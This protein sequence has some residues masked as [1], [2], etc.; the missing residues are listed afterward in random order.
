MA[1]PEA[2][3]DDEFDTRLAALGPFETRPHLAVA[4]SGGP[5]SMALALLANS[6]VEKRGG[7]LTALT[8]DHRLRSESVDEA[9]Q[10]HRWMDALGVEH[11]VLVWTGGK[12]AT[13]IQ[14]AA[15]EARYALLGDWCRT[16]G[17]L[18]LL[19]GHHLQ[20]QAET[21]LLRLAHGSGVDGLA[22]MAS[23]VETPA[24]RLLRPLLGVTPAALREY[25]GRRKQPWIDD[26]SNDDPRFARTW[27][28]RALPAL[29]GAGVGVAGL[30]AAADRVGQARAA[31]EAATGALLA[32]CCRLHPAGFARVRLP[33]LT[34]AP[35]E[36]TCRAVQQVLAVIGGRPHPPSTQA[37]GDLVGKVLGGDKHSATLAGCRILGDRHGLLICRERRG[38]P[39]PIAV[40][41]DAELMWDGRFQIRLAATATATG[42]AVWLVPLGETGWR[43]VVGACPALRNHPVPTAARPTLPALADDDGIALVPHLGY[44][45]TGG[46]GIGFEFAAVVLRPA[47]PLSRSEWFLAG[48]LS[49]IMS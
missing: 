7:R 1:E 49:R 12:P 36:I 20:D 18:H 41:G 15:R 8:V 33:A 48:P 24:V 3:L 46:A 10:V 34:A 25:L 13:G 4:V 29:A 27:L 28:R 32:D 14:E 40:R 22:A 44:R 19:L 6:W 47:I 35:T 23:V 5:D 31:L 30:A 16:A 39:A 21:V 17:V 38:L 45:R 26:P 43:Q 11:H 9:E 42:A 2:S 37:L